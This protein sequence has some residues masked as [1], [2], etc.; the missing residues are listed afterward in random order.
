MVKIKRSRKNAEPTFIEIKDCFGSGHE[1][2]KNF[3]IVVKNKCG[4]MICDE[5]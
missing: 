4:K 5:I 3:Q 1:G 2:L